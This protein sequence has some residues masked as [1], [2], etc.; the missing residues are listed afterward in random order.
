MSFNPESRLLHSCTIPHKDIYIKQIYNNNNNNKPLSLFKV[1]HDGIYNVNTNLRISSYNFGEGNKVIYIRNYVIIINFTKGKMFTYNTITNNI[2]N[3]KYPCNYLFHS[4]RPPTSNETI[5]G[6]MITIGGFHNNNVRS[7]IVNVYNIDND[8][9]SSVTCLPEGVMCHATVIVNGDIYVIG[10][11][12]TNSVTNKVIRYRDEVWETLAPL[13]DTRYGHIASV[14]DCCIYVYG[15]Y[16]IP[17]FSNTCECYDIVTNVW[18]SIV[19]NLFNDVI[20]SNSIFDKHIIYLYHKNNMYTICL[21]NKTKK[22][23]YTNVTVSMNCLFLM[24]L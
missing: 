11:A 5:Y 16:D 1:E 18:T 2:T 8:T 21:D 12:H 13:L 19:T 6:N 20:L 23:L 3:C 14:H 17:Y 24:S 22:L 9:W 7:N 10:G 4:N 15:G